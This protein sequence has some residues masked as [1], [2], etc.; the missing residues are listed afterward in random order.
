MVRTR[1]VIGGALIGVVAGGLCGIVFGEWLRSTTETRGR[2]DKVNISGLGYV[3]GDTLQEIT[4]Q[5]SRL[6]A[7][8]NCVIWSAIGGMVLGLVLVAFANRRATGLALVGFIVGSV[9][10]YIIWKNGSSSLDRSL[11]GEIIILVAFGSAIFGGILGGLWSI[12]RTHQQT[13][14]SDLSVASSASLP[15]QQ[16]SSVQ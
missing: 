5:E 6:T 13:R 15:T 4:R 3:R 8:L 14:A 9:V 12:I 10:G 16:Q 7:Q 1:R 2:E 11:T